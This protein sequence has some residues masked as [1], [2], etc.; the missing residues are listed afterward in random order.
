MAPDSLSSDGR[1][2]TLPRLGRFVGK[3]EGLCRR[4]ARDESA[5]PEVRE[6]ASSLAWIKSHLRRL[7]RYRSL[8]FLANLLGSRNSRSYWYLRLIRPHNLFQPFVDTYPDRYPEIFKFVRDQLGDS[9]DVRLL[10]FGCSTGEEVFSLR[11]YFPAAE[12]RALDIN[13][14]NIA[15]CLRRRRAAGDQRM[16]FAVAGSVEHEETKSY[17]AVFCMAVLRHGDL[18]DSNLQRC[19]HRITFAAFE[20]TVRDLGRCVKD[21]G[22]LI[23]QH[24]NFRFGDAVASTDFHP[25]L[26]VDNGDFVSQKPVFGVDNRRLDVPPYEEVVFRK[27][28]G[29]K[30]PSLA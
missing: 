27:R 30:A 2:L 10:S 1:G 15:V 29:L 9:P 6:S 16:S 4:F 20:L 23:I 22:L 13:P 12:I 28:Q 25:V 3:L 14:L 11:R 26:S 19:D 24:S 7:R 21:G 8:D 5:G 17:D 18:S